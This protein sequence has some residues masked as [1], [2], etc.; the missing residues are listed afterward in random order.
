MKTTANTPYNS[1]LSTSVKQSIIY[2][3]LVP[4]IVAIVVIWLSNHQINDF[5]SNQVNIA[6]SVVNSVAQE[7]TRLIDDN[8]RLLNIFIENERAN[9]K[10]LIAAPDSEQ[11]K[12]IIEKK[13]SHYFQEYFT[14]TVV[15]DSGEPIIDD[16]MGY[17]GDICLSDIKT[18]SN[19][20][21]QSIHVHPN[22]H[23][24]H[25][26][27]IARIGPQKKDG[28]FFASFGTNIFSRL[29]E[30]SSPSDQSLMLVN[31]QTPDLI[32]ITESG[33]R[34]SLERDNYTLTDSEKA[35]ILYSRAINGTSWRIA[36]VHD[37]QLF[38]DY[39]RDVI[40]IG[41]FIILL[42]AAGSILMALVL[43][44]TEKQRI[45]L[46]KTKDKMFTLF[47]HDLRS[48]LTSIYGTVQLLELDADAHGF[49]EVTRGMVSS[50]VE[51]AKHMIT[52][53]N[54]LLDNQKLE[55]GMMSFNF[56]NVELNTFVQ[57]VINLN[58]RLA[59]IRHIKLNFTPTSE[60]HVSIDRQRMQQAFTNL[61]SNAIK[62]SA[63]NAIVSISVS[64]SETHAEISVTDTG[65]GVS[66]DIR[67]M[68]FEKFTQSKSPTTSQ[69]GGTG[70]GLSI[71]K[72]IVEEHDGHV[73]FESTRGEGTT[74]V[75]RIPLNL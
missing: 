12:A 29:L 28:F 27:N 44:R 65:S 58:E 70:L 64:A 25:T 47:S 73:N 74:F 14:F 4:F 36:S 2:I 9:I 72:H 18:F 15:D 52:L 37:E 38:S 8:K 6:I 63:M 42:F 56:E 32:E 46:R 33:T 57:D 51:N 60:V 31:T 16:S 54:D 10:N 67:D 62:Y 59:A 66:E 34:T 17:I 49:N 30:L 24:I 35:R 69:A 11:Y 75:I 39:N 53:I 71:V 5:K 26:D 41:S 3:L 7:T 45:M 19:T 22:P 1:C 23:T 43:W 55:S 48:P 50:A 21:S 61:L 68:V 13:I 40:I 20:N